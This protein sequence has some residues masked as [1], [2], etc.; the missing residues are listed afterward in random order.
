MNTNEHIESRGVE[1]PDAQP[2][3]IETPEQQRDGDEQAPAVPAELPILP[4]RGQV[5]FPSTAQ[6][7]LIGQERSIKLI[8]D[9]MRGERLI[10]LVGQPNADVEQVPPEELFTVGVV[11]RIL[12]L[13]RRP[14][15]ALMIAVQGLQ[16]IRVVEYT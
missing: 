16:R 9:V 11:A 5:V 10:G 3:D 7:L 1:A 6:P 13:L 2:L 4:L 8:D 12:Q 15:G 14:D